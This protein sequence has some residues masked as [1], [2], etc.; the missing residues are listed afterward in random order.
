[1]ILPISLFG[2]IEYFNYLKVNPS[3]RLDV[4][5]HFPKQTH[6]NRFELTGTAG[7]MSITLPVIKPLGSKTPTGE[8]L[9]TSDKQER[10][11]IWRT[12]VANYASSPYFDHYESD[13]IQFFLDPDENLS[14]HCFALNR[15]FASV[16]D[17]PLEQTFTETFIPYTNTDAR[18]ID[19]LG[20]RDYNTYPQVLF[21][22]SF[23][24]ESNLSVLDLLMNEG[25][26][27]RFFI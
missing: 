6:R 12:V 15:F 11:K 9:I 26:M 25:P 14:Q 18:K 3:I 5:E 23:P 24:F 22:S 13:L 17:I 21:D 27:G 19:F 7:R 4:H 16:W 2:S 20:Q 10:L 8:V 1:M